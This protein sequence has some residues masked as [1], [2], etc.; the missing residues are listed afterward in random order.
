MCGNAVKLCEAHVDFRP[1]KLRVTVIV[2][3][4]PNA[5]RA[6]RRSA[7]ALQATRET[8]KATGSKVFP[9]GDSFVLTNW[10]VWSIVNLS[11]SRSAFRKLIAHY[12]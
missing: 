1:T 10:I 4:R 5:N 3:E 11:Q 8:D 2:Y 6:K 12:Y 7:R 9:G